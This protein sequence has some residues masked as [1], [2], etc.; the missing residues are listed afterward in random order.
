VI[1][2]DDLACFVNAADAGSFSI[3]ARRHDLTPAHVSHAVGRLEAAVG[4]RLFVRTTRSLRLSEDGERYLPHA[5]AALA[6][7]DGGSQALAGARGEISGPLRLTAPSDVGRNLLIGWLDAFQAA[8]PKLELHL[9]LSDQ[10]ADLIQQPLDGALRYGA[11]G[12]SALVA[13]PIAPDNRRTLC[14][15]PSYIARHGRPQQPEDLRHHNC[16]RFR[17]GEQTFERWRF[18]TPR[19]EQTITVTGNRVTDDADVARRWAIAG[20]GLVYKSRLDVWPDLQAGRLVEVFPPMQGEPSPL[21]LVCAHRASLTPAIQQLR[22]FLIEC[23]MALVAA[24]PV[25]IEAPQAPSGA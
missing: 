19:G 21:H 13:L 11:L 18:Y 10:S 5:R 3:A 8:H 15:A 24:P 9:R 20:H 14:A 6:A 16:L 1:R 17:W 23:C 7:V 22:A 25:Q 4:A 2:L 12:D